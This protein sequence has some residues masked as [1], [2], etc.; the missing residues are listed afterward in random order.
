MPSIPGQRPATQQAAKVSRP[1][2]AAASDARGALRPP[3]P[4]GPPDVPGPPQGGPAAIGPSGWPSS[5]GSPGP[6]V[7]GR[8]PA[9]QYRGPTN[10]DPFGSAQAYRPE[11]YSPPGV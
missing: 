10:Y 5:G 4:Y 1:P 7:E 8:A 3:N 2:S 9:E 11:A 6:P